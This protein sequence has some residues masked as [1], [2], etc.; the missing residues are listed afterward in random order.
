MNQNKSALGG[1]G[2]EAEQ[3]GEGRGAADGFAHSLTDIPLPTHVL[4]AGRWTPDEEE[5][6][7]SLIAKYK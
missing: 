2:R 5:R 4:T 1:R 7:K 3:P 6:L